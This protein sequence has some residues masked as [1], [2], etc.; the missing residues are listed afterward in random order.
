MSSTVKITPAGSGYFTTP[1]QSNETVSEIDPIMNNTIIIVIAT[2]C[3]A[4]SILLVWAITCCCKSQTCCFKPRQPNARFQY[5][6]AQ[7]RNLN[8]SQPR[9]R[10]RSKDDGC[11]TL[12]NR[13]TAGTNDISYLTDET[14]N[15]K[16]KL[17]CSTPHSMDISSN[18]GRG[19][20][21]KRKEM[22][23]T[24]KMLREE[25]KRSQAAAKASTF[26]QPTSDTDVCADSSL[27]SMSSIN[28]DSEKKALLRLQNTPYNQNLLNKQHKRNEDL[29]LDIDS[30]QGIYHESS[31]SEKD[32]GTG[33]SKRSN[34]NVDHDITLSQENIIHDNQVEENLAEEIYGEVGDGEIGDYHLSGG[35]ESAMN[36]EEFEASM[37][38][39]KINCDN[40]AEDSPPDSLNIYAPFSDEVDSAIG[41]RLSGEP[42]SSSNEHLLADSGCGEA[43]PIYSA[44]DS[45]ASS[46]IENN[47]DSSIF[48]GHM[49][50]SKTLNSFLDNS[51]SS[52]SSS[53]HCHSKH[54][55]AGKKRHQSSNDLKHNR[56]LDSVEKESATVDNMKVCEQ[57]SEFR[58]FY[59]KGKSSKGGGRFG[60]SYSTLHTGS[61]QNGLDCD[62]KPS[63]KRASTFEL[64]GSCYLSLEPSIGGE[65]NSSAVD[66]V[67]YRGGVGTLPKDT[68]GFELHQRLLEESL[69]NS[70]YALDRRRKIQEQ[71]QNF[72]R[73]ERSNSRTR[74][75]LI[76][77]RNRKNS[78]SKNNEIS[79]ISGS[80][81]SVQRN[82]GS[83]T[84]S[85][86]HSSKRGSS[87][88]RS[89][90]NKHKPP[91]G[92]SGSSQEYKSLLS[93][94]A[95]S[96]HTQVPTKSNDL[97]A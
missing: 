55:R 20:F 4:I 80:S 49:Q 89:K 83:F 62:P 52:I 50:P 95:A 5:N 26:Y 22:D 43:M 70:D 76:F 38:T 51:L 74:R 29:C 7:Q 90:S 59:P 30:S 35:G 87:K 57:P 16:S 15:S 68:A 78:T 61:M 64:N 94:V 28:D 85:L 81:T 6:N 10:A 14:D 97:F 58:T 31:S 92:Y 32:S 53:S 2:S 34:E 71:Q 18:P 19:E 17:L 45:I 88:T 63:K 54:Q 46:S 39:L 23:I 48:G 73:K 41:E 37:G 84:N 44:P 25:M 79:A 60:A 65:L 72:D 75:S 9:G 12:I 82:N 56:N 42:P 67:L 33:D 1:R 8:M 96:E 66:P 77:G 93:R 91:N 11:T 36:L 27:L 24:N 3:A 13:P 21:E 40:G 47:T 86:P 69:N